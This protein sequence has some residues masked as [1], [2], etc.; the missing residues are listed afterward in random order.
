[1]K[2]FSI[3]IVLLIILLIIL[4]ASLT[5]VFVYKKEKFQDANCGTKLN[6]CLSSCLVKIRQVT[7][8][9]ELMSY[10]DCLKNCMC[11]VA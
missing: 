10:N 11:G 5:V 4:I 3:I 7:S 6:G 9:G 8:D 1:M 2:K